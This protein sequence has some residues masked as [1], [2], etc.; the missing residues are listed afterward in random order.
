M[1]SGT[2]TSFSEILNGIDKG[3]IKALLM[4]EADPFSGF[5]DQQ[6]M[7]ESMK[8]LDLLILMDYLPTPSAERAHILLPTATLFETDSCW[9]NHEGR[10]QK[11]SAVHRGGIPIRQVSGGSHPPRLFD[12]SCS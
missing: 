5:P 10:L 1:L 11:A 12:D 2:D 9:V 8:R 7:I 6:R 3:D 4:V